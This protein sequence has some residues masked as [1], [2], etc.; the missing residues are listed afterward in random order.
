MRS[1]QRSAAQYGSLWSA[2][3]DVPSY[4]PLDENTRA[5][6]AIVGAGIA[7]LTTA[8]LLARTGRSVVV[9]D[10]GPV[11]GG[12]TRYTTAHLTWAID[13]RYYEIERIHGHDGARLAAAS[14]RAAVDQIEA[15]VREERIECDF[16]RVDGF[17]FQDSEPDVIDRELAAARRAGV[18]VE[19]LHRAPLDGYD[20]GP[21]LRFP[22][23]GQFHPLKYLAGLARAIEREGG[24]IYTGTHIDTIVGG[25]SARVMAGR[26][27]VRTN[28]VVVATNTPVNDRVAI[29]TKQAPY[30]SYVIAA[31][32]PRGSVATGLYWDTQD[33]YHYV[34]VHRDDADEDRD[35]LIVGGE[36]HKTG[37]AQDTDRRHARLETWARRRFPTMGDVEFRWAGQVMETMDGLAFIGRNPLDEN[38]VFIATGDSGQGM[39]HGTIAGMLLTDLINHKANPWTALYEPSRKRIGAVGEFAKEAFN[40][41]AQYADW[42]TPGEETDTA[43]LL[44]GQGAVM[45]RGLKKHAVYRDDRGALHEL[46]AVCPHLGCIVRWNGT[47]KTWD[48]PCHGSRFDKL[49]SVINGPANSDL[50]RLDLP[51]PP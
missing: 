16:A 10:D 37:Q 14:H 22:D 48:C 36:D 17:L 34:R 15:I 41:M 27:R 38:N 31:S 32:I 46:S 11:A 6:V 2:T 47:E 9:I 45:R 5:D 19:R 42:V 1:T 51:D 12:M 4:P 44:P 50:N 13:D 3:A 35:L 33:P 8:Y 18:M 40:M 28:A 29:H 39:T 30:M 24:R 7:G 21:C 20:T 43:S 26:L 25:S 49:G 23:Q